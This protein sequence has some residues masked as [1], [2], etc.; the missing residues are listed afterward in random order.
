VALG[1]SE[2]YLTERKSGH[3]ILVTDVRLMLPQQ[4]LWLDSLL[5]QHRTTNRSD[6]VELL[7]CYGIRCR[8]WLTSITLRGDAGPMPSWGGIE[9]G[10]GNWVRSIGAAQLYAEGTDTCRCSFYNHQLS[11]ESKISLP[12]E[13]CS[14]GIVQGV[15]RSYCTAQN[16]WQARAYS[17]TKLLVL[18]CIC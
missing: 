15:N 14:I 5:V 9:V 8:L 16:C 12:M 3:C 11:L 17:H 6:T 18:G 7:G 13:T 1:L 4:H 2:F 10:G